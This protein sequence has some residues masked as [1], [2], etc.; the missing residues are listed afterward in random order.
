MG[1]YQV[2]HRPFSKYVKTTMNKKKVGKGINFVRESK[3]KHAYGIFLK[4]LGTNIR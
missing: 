2:S 3:P 4:E 1:K